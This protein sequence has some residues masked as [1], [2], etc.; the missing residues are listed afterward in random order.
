MNF[1]KYINFVAVGVLLIVISSF[2]YASEQPASEMKSS[3]SSMVQNSD[4]TNGDTEKAKILLSKMVKAIHGMDYRGKFVFI[5]AS[6]V[7]AAELVH[8]NNYKSIEYERVRTLDGT[9]SE[10]VRING[11][12]VGDDVGF[13]GAVFDR[14][15][16]RPFNN[17]FSE[18]AVFDEISDVYSLQINENQRIAGRSASQ[19]LIEP[20][21]HSRY[22]YHFWIDNETSM[23]LKL[24]L[25]D[26]GEN[27]EQFLFVDIEIPA[28]ITESDIAV[29]DDDIAQVTQNSNDEIVIG[30]SGSN[31]SIWT[32]AAIPKGFKL[33]GYEKKSIQ[34]EEKTQEQDNKDFLEH[35]IYSDGIATISVYIEPKLKGASY[36][37][38]YKLG[39]LS[40]YGVFMNN[41]QITVLGE[42][43]ITTV[44]TVSRSVKLNP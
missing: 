19:V 21:D 6:R 16:K 5:S 15:H 41:Y 29:S 17:L 10:I 4:V 31:E 9:Q 30:D 1:N 38:S 36:S 3:I 32:I 8:K 33:I 24:C 42:V 37:G 40:G 27:V 34:I 35:F 12:L 22:G 18:D 2:T 7:I 20:D 28:T 13:Q 44:E 26:Q 43:P 23:I 25:M 11:G 14:F 39:V